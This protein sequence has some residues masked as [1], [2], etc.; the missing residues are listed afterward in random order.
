[1]V[2]GGLVK[3]ASPAMIHAYFEYVTTEYPA[4]AGHGMLLV[5]LH[6]ENAGRRMRP[7]GCCAGPGPAPGSA[8]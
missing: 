3:R 5:Q 7:A 8:R 2:T 1:M 6:G 4:D